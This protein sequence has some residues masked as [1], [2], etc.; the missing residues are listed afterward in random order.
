[1]GVFA[2]PDSPWWWLWLETTQQKERTD[3]KIGTTHAQRTDSQRLA[4][5][6]YHQRMNELA[7][8]LYKLPSALPAIRFRKYAEDYAP[9]IA[10]HR[11]AE[12]ER[13]LLKPL[14]AFFGDH[15]LTAIDPERVTVYMVTRKAKVSA[16]TVNREVGLLKSMIRDAAPKY[17][18]ESPLVGM[19]YLPT[20]T[21]RRRLMTEAEERR[22]LAKADPVET[23]LLVLG[24]DGLIRLTDLL[25]LR[26]RDRHGPWLYVAQPKSGQPY[27]VALSPRA[28]AALDALPKGD[29]YFAR[30]RGANKE[31]DRRGRV[32]KALKRLCKRAHVRYGW[33]V[34]GIT[35]HWATRKTGA[36]RLIQAGAPIPSV[37]RQG[38]WKTSD[39]LLSIYAEADKA[40]QLRMVSRI[41]HSRRARHG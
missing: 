11:G 13:E 16:R 30:Y 3:I 19:K 21:P 31:R 12:R 40:A 14:V 17:L 20:T 38:N 26:R 39:V 25:D 5:D 41:P 32:R 24:L 36:T 23:A 10:T 34:G 4:S 37:Q 2:R 22:L 18:S 1:M 7:A 33:K 9:T 29:Y 28:K 8:R 15:L 35:F 6:R 27:E